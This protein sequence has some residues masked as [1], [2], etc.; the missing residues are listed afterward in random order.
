MAAV[1]WDQ[2]DMVRRRAL[3]D[4][5]LWGWLCCEV[6]EGATRRR[7]GRY[8]FSAAARS[9]LAQENGLPASAVAT[10]AFFDVSFCD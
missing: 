5:L 8:G 6:Q 10:V 3:S 9:N 2:K 1:F 7:R 4:E